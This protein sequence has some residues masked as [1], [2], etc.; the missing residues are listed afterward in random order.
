MLKVRLL[1]S[2]LL[3]DRA[4]QQMDPG[5]AGH[6]PHGVGRWSGD[7]LRVRRLL[8]PRAAPREHLRQHH[9]AGAPARGLTHERRGALEVG[10]A[11]RSGGHLPDGSEK[12]VHDAAARYY[13]QPIA[14][15]WRRAPQKTKH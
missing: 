4:H 5:G 11:A 7:R 15:Q 8:A 12:P 9:Q 3:Q 10:L 14:D 13:A 2:G 6:L 1:A